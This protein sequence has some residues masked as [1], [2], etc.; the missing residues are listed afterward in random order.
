VPRSPLP[1]V[2]VV[3]SFIDAI[4]RGDLDRLAAL[5]HDQHRLEV[6]DEDAVVGREEN[7]RAW[8]DY[9]DAFPR[10]VIHPRFLR[11]DGARVAI[12]GTTTGS[13]L[14][15]PDTE[16]MQLAVIWVSEVIDGSVM[17]WAIHEDDPRT[18]V[19]LGIPVDV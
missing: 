19:E 16:E 10:Y 7:A 8:R 2:A 17:R 15:L 11:A 9:F 13:H 1:P 18:R 5:V 3:I 4:N 14:D 6:L 12:L